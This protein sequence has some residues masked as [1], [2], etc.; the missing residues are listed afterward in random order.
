[1]KIEHDL[2]PHCEY[3][4]AA[5][6]LRNVGISLKEP[7]VPLPDG[8]THPD[9]TSEVYVRPCPEHGGKPAITSGRTLRAWISYEAAARCTSCGGRLTV[10]VFDGQPPKG[11]DDGIRYQEVIILGIGNC[12][13]CQIVTADKLSLS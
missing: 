12:P 5:H 1:M 2:C 4:D 13:K 11:H 9:P 6:V 10:K 3:A 8:W 7:N